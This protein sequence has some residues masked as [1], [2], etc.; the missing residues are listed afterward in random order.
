MELLKVD[1]LSDTLVPL[2]HSLVRVD[3]AFTYEE[4]VE[5]DDVVELDS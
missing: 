2:E 4:V 1:A 3:I 5:E